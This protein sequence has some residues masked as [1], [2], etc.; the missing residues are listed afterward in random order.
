MKK[1]PWY[2]KLFLRRA[3]VILAMMLQAWLMVDILLDFSRYSPLIGTIH[4]LSSF[5]VAI[6]IA[7][8][9]NKS[10][11]RRFRRQIEATQAEFASA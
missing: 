11:S 10:A 4:S 3:L 1:R 7:S 6:Y 8:R 5:A 9:R 2:R